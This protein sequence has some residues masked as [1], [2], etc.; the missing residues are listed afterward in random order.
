MTDRYYSGSTQAS[1]VPLRGWAPLLLLTIFL[2]SGLVGHD[3]WKSEDATH[4]GIVW[5]LLQ[6]DGSL[7]LQLGGIPWPDAMPLYYW[8][9]T[10]FAQAFSWLLPWF[11]GARLATAFFAALAMGFLALAS[12]ELYGKGEGRSAALLL[13]GCLGFLVHSHEAQPAIAF[14]AAEAAVLA[15]LALAGRRPWLGASLAGIAALAAFLTAG[16]SALPGLLLPLLLLPRLAPRLAQGPGLLLMALGLAALGPLLWPQLLP[17]PQAAAWWNSELSQ[18]RG[19]ELSL[20]GATVLAGMLPWY[21]WPALPLALWALWSE[22]RQLLCTRPAMP[23]VLPLTAFLASFLN[24]VATA[25]ARSVAALPLLPPL[26]LLGTA[27][28]RSLRRGAANA[29]DWFGMMTFTVAA[30]LIWLGWVAMVFDIPAR[31]ARNFAKLAPGFAA[32][33]DPLAAGFALALNLAWIWLIFSGPRSVYRGLIHWT[34]GMTLL[35]GLTAALWFPWVDYGKSYRTVAEGLS[36]AV[37]RQPGCIAVRGELPTALRASLDIFADIRPLALDSDAGQ[38]CH[39]LLALV[40]IKSSRTTGT[41]WNQVWEGSRPGDKTE[42]LRL[43]Q[44]RDGMK[45]QKKKSEADAQP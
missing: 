13:A 14:L 31:I 23:L 35:W 7:S 43:Y 39:W 1:T 34:G 3:P 12:R 30:G 2:L 18:L 8:V 26:V 45:L 9:A 21:A 20:R 22:R 36:A 19:L 11:D 44:R 6:G 15:G 28:I 16:L 33:I 40:P 24:I 25:D 17:P 42:H 38:R 5:R 37:A 41:G 29:F 4:L 10:L 32:G 27:G